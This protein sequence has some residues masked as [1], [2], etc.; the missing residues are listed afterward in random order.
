MTEHDKNDDCLRLLRA[1][2]AEMNAALAALAGN[3]FA[4]FESSVAAQQR[5]CEA[6]RGLAQ[7]SGGIPQPATQLAA[8]S[9]EL[10]QQNRVYVAV[11]TR[12]AQFGAALLSLYQG[13]PR[14]YSRQGRLASTTRTWS[15]EV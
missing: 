4:R 6:V 10:R 11:L 3:D 7:S 8:A 5:L 14:G 15:C 13:S 1:L 2:S 12:A 9:Q